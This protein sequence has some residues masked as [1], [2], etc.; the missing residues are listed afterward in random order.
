M[1]PRSPKFAAIPKAV[2]LALAFG[3]KQEDSYPYIKQD[4]NKR[5]FLK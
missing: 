4:F 5:F 2:S 1:K 3:M